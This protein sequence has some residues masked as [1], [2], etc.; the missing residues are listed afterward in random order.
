[1]R[2][3]EGA[4][5]RRERGRGERSSAM[6]V[7][8]NIVLPLFGLMLCGYV[9]VLAGLF[10]PEAV[11]GLS[12]F[13]FFLAIP[14]LLF[15]GI[16]SATPGSGDDDHGVRRRVRP[17]FPAHAAADAAGAA[18]EPAADG[19]PPR[20]RRAVLRL[21]SPGRARPHGRAPVRRGGAVL[22]LC[23]G[24]DDEELPHRRR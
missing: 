1:P 11:K 4:D 16:S 7:A 24:D 2:G 22:A 18:E 15:P 14:A 3:G 20:L 19:D 23:V 21:A 13:V 6:T 9:S 12:S 5:R 10:R 17:P 8:F